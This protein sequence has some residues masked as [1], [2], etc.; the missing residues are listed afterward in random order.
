[1]VTKWAMNDNSAAL[2]ALLGNYDFLCTAFKVPE[3]SSIDM[4]RDIAIFILFLS[5]PAI[6]YNW[7][8]DVRIILYR[9]YAAIS[10][11]DK[12]VVRNASVTLANIAERMDYHDSLLKYGALSQ[13]HCF[14]RQDCSTTKC[15]AMRALIH[16]LK[17]ADCCI[18]QVIPLLDALIFLK[19][20]KDEAEE[21]FTALIFRK[22]SAYDCC[23]LWFLKEGLTTLLTLLRSHSVRTIRHGARAF[24]NLCSNERNVTTLN[25]TDGVD[26]ILISLLKH[27]TLEIKCIGLSVLSDLVAVSNAASKVSGYGV[28]LIPLLSR[29]KQSQEDLNARIV[30]VLVSISEYRTN[31]DNGF[32]IR[33]ID[34]LIRFAQSENAEIRQVCYPL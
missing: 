20:K 5:R 34:A 16:I 14:I 32:L 3:V 7:A 19:H 31:Q 15:E 17:S 29:I 33:S 4:E 18:F 1:M 27:E 13:I 9:L 10:S 30:N 23:Q 22:I 21:Y 12:V 6:R 25:Q 24:R 26:E 2:L 28:S 11:A 8:G